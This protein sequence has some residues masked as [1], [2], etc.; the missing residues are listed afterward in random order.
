MAGCTSTMASHVMVHSS[1]LFPSLPG[2]DGKWR[3]AALFLGHLK[4]AALGLWMKMTPTTFIAMNNCLRSSADQPL[5]QRSIPLARR[6]LVHPW[7]IQKHLQKLVSF[8]NGKAIWW[9]HSF[10]SKAA[11]PEKSL[12]IWSAA[13]E[14]FKTSTVVPAQHLQ[15]IKRAA[16]GQ[17]E[18]HRLVGF[19]GTTWQPRLT[20]RALCLGSSQEA[21]P[22]SWGSKRGSKEGQATG[23]RKICWKESGKGPTWKVDP[24]LKMQWGR[25]L[26]VNWKGQKK[27]YRSWQQ[28]IWEIAWE[29]W[30]S[31]PRATQERE[32]LLLLYFHG[33]YLPRQQLKARWSILNINPALLET[34][35]HLFQRTRSCVLNKH[36]HCL[37]L[38]LG[39]LAYLKFW[40]LFSLMLAFQ[41]FLLLAFPLVTLR[42]GHPGLSSDVENAKL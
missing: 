33:F 24:L 4:N 14:Y 12:L 30:A 11:A 39:F 8:G 35:W 42:C 38:V 20:I 18:T 15:G 29:E 5:D 41:F 7:W 28:R 13:H 26:E 27:G 10:A 23:W 1:T 2:E 25:S 22:R 19:E 32:N 6:P 21:L 17:E 40:S 37:S 36:E 16:V 34:L 31:Q 3:Q 9:V